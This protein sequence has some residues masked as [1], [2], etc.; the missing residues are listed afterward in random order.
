MVS[1]KLRF[2]VVKC[3]GAA[4]VVP[5]SAAPKNLVNRQVAQKSPRIFVLYACTKNPE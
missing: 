2:K 1:Q 5:P 4:T 3:V